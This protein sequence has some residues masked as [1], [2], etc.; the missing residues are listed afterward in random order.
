M[1]LEPNMDIYPGLDLGLKNWCPFRFPLFLYRR[2]WI[3]WRG[4][5]AEYDKKTVIFGHSQTISLH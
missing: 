5:C 2:F 3:V 1:Q 4:W